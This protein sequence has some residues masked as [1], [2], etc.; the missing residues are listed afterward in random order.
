[1]NNPACIIMILLT[2]CLP[3][4]RGPYLHHHEDGTCVSVCAGKEHA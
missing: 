1:M 3:W 4:P 2:L